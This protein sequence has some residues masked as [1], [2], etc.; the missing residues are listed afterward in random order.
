MAV[1]TNTYGDHEDVERLIGDIV[2]S[3]TFTDSTTPTITQVEAELDNVAAE[4]NA[5]L[6]VMGYTV[7]VSSTDY[8]TAYAF[9]TA[10]NNYGAA[11]RILGT[12]PTEAYN[13]DEQMVDIGM[14]RAEMYER[15]LKNALAWIW[16]RR[17]RAGMRK[18]RFADLRVGARTDDDGNALDPLYRRRMGEKSGARILPAAEAASEDT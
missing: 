11:A 18:E 13:P 12:I 5:A 14:S 4:I 16:S 8:P 9:L 6:D 10:A 15:H 3:R 17:L 7:P 2:A 1:G